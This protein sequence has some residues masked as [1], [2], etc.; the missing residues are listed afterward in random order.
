[1]SAGDLL[2][3]LPVLGFSSI[4]QLLPLPTPSFASL[5][6]LVC[7]LLAY[8]CCVAFGKYYPSLGLKPPLLSFRVYNWV[9]SAA[10]SNL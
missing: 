1:M 7:C 10:F 9:P 8:I 3:L 4:P 2:A 6:L 5:S